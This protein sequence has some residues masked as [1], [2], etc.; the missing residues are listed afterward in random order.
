VLQRVEVA[1]RRIAARGLLAGDH[2]AGRFV[3]LAG[4][5][6][7]EAK[8]GEAA[9]HVATLAAIET[10]LVLGGLARFLGEGRWIDVG[11]RW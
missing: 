4:R 3:E 5:L 7:V 6:D 1:A 9:L 11:A 10:E 2:R 8:P